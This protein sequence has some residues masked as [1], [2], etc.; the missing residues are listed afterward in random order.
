M[1][2][3]GT[4]GKPRRQ[5]AK[6]PWRV[7]VDP[8]DIPGGYCE[9]KHRGLDSTIA[10]REGGFG[11]LRMMACHEPPPGKELPCVGWL[12]NQLGAGNNIALRLTVVT[13]RV[14]GNVETVGAQHERFEDTLPTPGYMKVRA[15]A[16]A[17]GGK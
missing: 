15:R 16:A 3:A 14:D 5:C 7:D 4:A 8:N 11:P 6:C 17:R 13:G 2:G 12:E 10:R 9:T 1:S